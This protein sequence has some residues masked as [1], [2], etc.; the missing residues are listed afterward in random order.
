MHLGLRRDAAQMRIAIAKAL[1]VRRMINLRLTG[2]AFYSLGNKGGVIE[3]EA[4]AARKP[5]ALGTAA[6]GKIHA[7]S[8]VGL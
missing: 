3:G 7:L 2:E 5:K 6:L 8:A 1:Y 4:A